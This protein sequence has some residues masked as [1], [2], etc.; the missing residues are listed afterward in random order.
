MKLPNAM[1]M[2]GVVCCGLCIWLSAVA[3]GANQI[4][5]SH[6]DPDNLLGLCQD[7]YYTIASWALLLYDLLHIVVI[8]VFALVL[9]RAFRWEAWM[10][11]GASVISSVAAVS[12]VSVNV[13]LLMA[14][15]RAMAEG[16]ASGLVTPEA[17]YDVICSTLDFAQ[18]SFG[19]VGTLFLATAAIKATGMAK[20][21]GWFLLI[22][23]PIS[24]LQV[25]QV[26]IHAPWTAIVDRWVTPIDEIIQQI[27]IGLALLAILKR[28]LEFLEVKRHSGTSS[29]RPQSEPLS[30]QSIRHR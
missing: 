15:L 11:G 12:S 3:I 27:V 19:L 1:L 10:G 30:L 8:V 16:K 18:A 29:L 26:G 28:R 22:G 13:F 7:L 24:F 2:A 21:A 5:F 9:A 23:L 6:L 25:A 20:I 17:G 4:A 14:T